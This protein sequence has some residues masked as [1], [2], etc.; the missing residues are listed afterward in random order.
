MH[1]PVL[2][3]LVLVAPKP[4]IFL[5][6][7]KTKTLPENDWC[8]FLK[9]FQSE[10][11]GACFAPSR[12]T[13]CPAVTKCWLVWRIR[14]NTTPISTL[15]LGEVL[16][17]RQF[18]ASGQ[19][20]PFTM[21][22]DHSAKMM[23]IPVPPSSIAWTPSA[24]PLC[25]PGGARSYASRPGALGSPTSHVTT[26]LS[27]HTS[28]SCTLKPLGNC[29]TSPGLTLRSH[30]LKGRSLANTELPSHWP[31]SCR[32]TTPRAKVR[33]MTVKPSMEANGLVS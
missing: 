16:A 24:W 27:S 6:V 26:Q 28:V 19:V 5:K 22:D 30:W 10:T 1:R 4:R 18:I 11:M 3:R 2:Q 12:H 29:A 13:F 21:K 15:K 8:D 9:N 14:G 31:A 17:H 7:P 23:H 33:R 20:R 32:L 25:S